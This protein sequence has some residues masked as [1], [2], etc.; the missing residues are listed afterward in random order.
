[1]NIFSCV[2]TS[3]GTSKSLQKQAP[4]EG[5][6]HLEHAAES[7]FIK[8]VVAQLATKIRVFYCT[9]ISLLFL[10]SSHPII[11]PSGS[12]DLSKLCSFKTY[13]TIMFLFTTWSVMLVSYIPVL[14]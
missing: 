7:A 3:Q 10:K 1:M 14:R 8:L 13:F 6:F 11:L 5:L 9:Q 4:I 2:A 12:S